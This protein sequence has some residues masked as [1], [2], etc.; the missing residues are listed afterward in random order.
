ME[1]TQE[2]ALSQLSKQLSEYTDEYEK[3][4]TGGDPEMATRWAALRLKLL[5]MMN[6]VTGLYNERAPQTTPI[7]VVFEDA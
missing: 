2:N 1:V 5:D 6:K 7:V 4:R 3:A